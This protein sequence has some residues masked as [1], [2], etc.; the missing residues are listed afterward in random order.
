MGY[1]EVTKIHEAQWIYWHGVEDMYAWQAMNGLPRDKVMIQAGS[2]TVELVDGEMQLYCD[3]Y[4]LQPDGKPFLE[5]NGEIMIRSV[6]MPYV[7]PIPEGIGQ[8]IDWDFQVPKKAR[9]ALPQIEDD[10]A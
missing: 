8:L 4:P 9:A 10:A 7:E 2:V 5:E 6:I 1:L 3:V